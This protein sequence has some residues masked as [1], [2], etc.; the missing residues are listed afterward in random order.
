MRSLTR[1]RR[2]ARKS[3]YLR[4]TRM[5]VAA[6]VVLAF[7]AS[8]VAPLALASGSSRAISVLGRLPESSEANDSQRYIIGIDEQRDRLL[9]VWR[10]NA[11]INLNEYDLGSVVPKLVREKQI[12]T[13]DEFQMDYASPYTIAIDYERRLA[14]FMAASVPGTAIRVVDLRSLDVVGTWELGSQLPGFFGEGITYS[15]EDKRLYMVGNMYGEGHVPVAARLGRVSPGTAVVAVTP[16]KDP[17]GEPQVIWARAVPQCQYVLSTLSVGALIARSADQAALYFA[18]VRPEPYTGQS[19]LIRLWIDPKADH[20][21]AAAFQLDFFPISGSYTTTTE[22][23]VGT[24]AFDQVSE[25]FFIQSVSA[26]TP[27]TWVFDGRLSSWVGFIAAPNNTNLYQ[28][29]D[30]ESGRFYMGSPGTAKN[31]ENDGYLLVTDGRATPIPQG[32]IYSGPGVEGFVTT[33]P[34]SDRLFVRM[35]LK[36]V[37]FGKG[38]KEGFVVFGDQTPKPE[39]PR[40]LD[41]DELTSDLP[42]G[43]KTISDY[44]GGINGYGS[45]I[46]LVGGFGG[47]LSASGQQIPLGPLR[48]GDR[49]FTAARL[50]SLDLRTAGASATARAF[51]PDLNTE[52]EIKDGAG[53]EWP[54]RVVS[55]L[56]GGGESISDEDEQHA[57][58]AKVECDIEKANAEAT[59]RFGRLETAGISV[60]Y[61]SMT[62]NAR[63]DA[64]L[65][66][67]TRVTAEAKGIEIATP[68]GT[69]RIAKVASEATTVAHG[70]AKS[71]VADWTRFVSGVEVVDANGQVVQELG[72]CHSSDSE[73]PCGPLEKQIN[74]LLPQKVKVEFP[75]PILPATPKGA[76]AGVQQS[77][78]DYY[79][80][81]TVNNQGTIFPGEEASKAVPAM[82]VTVYNDTQEKSRLIV[83]LA[84]IQANSIY[85]ISPKGESP[86]PGAEVV[87]VAPANMSSGTGSAGTSGSL[88][89]EPVGDAGD[90]GGDV[91]TTPTDTAAP[92]LAAQPL[93]GTLAFIKRSPQ[94]AAL[95]ALIWLTFGAA[96]W[97]MFRRGKLIDVLR[98]G[99]S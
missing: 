24:A 96:G 64:K 43:E 46:L 1:E 70:H 20:A 14:Y 30:L 31:E 52:A 65:G 16:P 95:V 35:K 68:G 48:G 88:D 69:L 51:V 33:D 38:D 29:L 25:R 6:A 11:E 61:S 39:R 93:D 58:Y 97:T 90:I 44:S 54:W 41:Y 75:K 60:A 36:S 71:A 42:E 63:R 85:T 37:G 62:A 91:T 15:E 12:G 50:S 86:I 76:F 55:C 94:E 28:G 67:V 23:V 53:Q 22:G 19:A 82:Q 27:G 99:N 89:L 10:R 17:T 92:V 77:D 73:N 8:A 59:A 66:T 2:S 72:S 56:N 74:D 80:N 83:L 84:A 87:N 78:A 13:Y 5:S 21:A 4:V 47:V 98:G 34:R 79:G 45:R 3:A 9:Y 26:T 18:C 81:Q 40:P 32:R 49:G 7:G 57:G